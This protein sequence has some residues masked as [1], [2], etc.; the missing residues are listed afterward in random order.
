MAPTD[1]S[2]LNLPPGVKLEKIK[3]DPL[4]PPALLE[5]PRD[6]SAPLT[7]QSNL[8]VTAITL[9][10]SKSELKFD[11]EIASDFD[12]RRTGLGGRTEFKAGTAMLFVH[13]TTAVY[14]YWMKDVPFGIDMIYITFDGKIAALQRMKP[15][16]RVAGEDPLKYELRLKQYSSN[17]PVNFALELPEGSIDALGLRLGD[18]VIA[19]PKGFL[20]L[21]EGKRQQ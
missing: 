7:V 17:H 20:K 12:A 16:P 19:D 14:S 1:P 9:K 5:V 21:C 8:P 15:Q 2:Q 4:Q 18:R 10:G 11:V 6:Y 3:R 13:P